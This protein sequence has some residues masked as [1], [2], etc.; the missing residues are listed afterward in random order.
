ML[1]WG[2]GQGAWPLG[3]VGRV[4]ALPPSLVFFRSRA[5]FPSSLFTRRV[6]VLMALATP[7]GRSSYSTDTDV[8]WWP[9]VVPSGTTCVL[10]SVGVGDLPIFL[11]GLLFLGMVQGAQAVPAPKD[12][13]WLQVLGSLGHGSIMVQQ[14]Q[15]QQVWF[16]DDAK[17]LQMH[18]PLLSHVRLCDPV[19]CN[20]PGSSVHG[21][22]QART[23][24]RV[25][26]SFSRGIF[27]AQGLNLHL[28]N[29]AGRFFTPAPPGKPCKT[30]ALPCFSSGAG[31]G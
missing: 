20:P 2:A 31:V 21:I 22:S 5:I 14:S 23:L 1:I 9:G 12:C 11:L 15:E 6:C 3:G 30:A 28:P 27:P 13:G 10:P 19:D 24:D 4:W 8:R 26:I 7:S 25:A 18:A 29:L 17:L 16:S